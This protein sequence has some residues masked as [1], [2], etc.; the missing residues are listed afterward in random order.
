MVSKR[1]LYES[2]GVREY[3]IVDPERRLVMAF[4]LENGKYTNMQIVP[5]DEILTSIV[6]PGLEIDLRRAFG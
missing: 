2:F 5:E 1:L 3:L 4:R 6:L